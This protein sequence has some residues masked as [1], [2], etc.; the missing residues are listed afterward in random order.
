MFLQLRETIANFIL[1]EGVAERRRLERLANVDQL[2]GLANR[3]AFDLAKFSAEGN[4]AVAVVLFDANNFG[5]VNKI[6]GH[7]TGDIVLKQLADCIKYQAE[8]I[9]FG[10]RCFR[11]G[12]DEFV[13]LLPAYYAERFRAKVEASFGV[14]YFAEIPVSVSGSIGSNLAEADNILQSRK[15]AQKADQTK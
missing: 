10:E 2:T 13:V 4:A 7:E 15:T 9:G 14:H 1:P 8:R 3:R 5:K 12:G 11:L 6:A